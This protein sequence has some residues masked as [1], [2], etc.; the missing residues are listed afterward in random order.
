MAAA[1]TVPNDA[2]VDEFLNAVEPSRRREDAHALRAL[3]SR[4]S[5]FEPVLW[6]PSIVGF[7]TTTYALSRGRTSDIMLIGFSPRKT[8]LAL[9]GYTRYP[10]ADAD[11]E[12]LGKHKRGASCLY[13]TKLMDVDVSVLEDMTRAS[14]RHQNADVRA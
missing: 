1:K 5:G 6:G 10:S 2:S 9:Y 13:V 12:R 7:G 4:I 8:A 14:L 3:M 11:L